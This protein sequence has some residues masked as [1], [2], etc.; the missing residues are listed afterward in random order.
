MRDFKLD[1]N[2]IFPSYDGKGSRRQS[3]P[4]T[5]SFGYQV[6]GFGSGGTSVN[7]IPFGYLLVA[8][9]G[10]GGS[11]YG[12]GGGGGGMREFSIPQGQQEVE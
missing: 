10:A 9:G 3:G 1:P 12:G 5:K 7:K 2:K 8:G 4:K 6:L 11:N